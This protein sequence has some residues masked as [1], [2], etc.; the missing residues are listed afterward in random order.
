MLEHAVDIVVRG[1]HW[2]S[3]SSA[4]IAFA[5][6]TRAL[7]GQLGELVATAVGQ[8]VE[9][10]AARPARA[11]PIARS[12][13]RA[14]EPALCRVERAVSDLERP[15]GGGDQ[16]RHDLVSVE[17]SP[18]ANRCRT[19]SSS[20]PRLDSAANALAIFPARRLRS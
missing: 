19:I 4:D 13:T 20:D 14:L 2:P 12:Q 9:M 11:S 15:V 3:S 6:V 16:L 7:V 18:A 5:N 17:A 8:L 1:S 10:S